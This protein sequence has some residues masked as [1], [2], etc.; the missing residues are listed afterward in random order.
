MFA[1]YCLSKAGVT[2][3]PQCANCYRWRRKLG[4]D[5]I[6]DE[7]DYIPGPGDLIFF[8]HDRDDDP[9]DKNFPNHVGIVTDYDPE[10]EMVH[11]VEGNAG[12]AVRARSYSRSNASITGYVSMR[13]CMIRWDKAYKKRLSKA[14]EEDLARV[15]G[16]EATR[17][18]RRTKSAI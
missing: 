8:H 13:K 10:T 15:K 2:C 6:D 14:L 3:L 1:S 5:Y 17:R 7:D 12:L 18:A 11:T 4:R 16:N 9:K